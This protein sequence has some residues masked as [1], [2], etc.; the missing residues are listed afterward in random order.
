MAQMH[1][2]WFVD[3]VNADLIHVSSLSG[4]DFKGKSPFQDIEI[5]TLGSFGHSLIL[6]GKVQSTEKDEVCYHET[7][8]HPTLLLHPTG[9]KRVFIGGGGEGATS[10]EVLKHK[11]VEDVVMVDIDQVCVD[12]CRKYMPKHSA[13]AFDDPRHKLIIED[14]KKILEESEDGSYDAIILDLADPLD[15]GPCYQ[16]YTDSFYSMCRN[17]LSKDGILITQSGPCG[18]LSA[19]EVFS[20]IHATLRSVFPDST[21]MSSTLVLSFMD[22]YGFNTALNNKDSTPNPIK[23][24][25]EEID[26]RIEERIEGGHNALVWYDG[27]THQR[28]FHLPKSIRQ[29][30]EKERRIITKD[31][32][33]FMV[34]S[35]TPMNKPVIL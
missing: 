5:I 4:I 27:I 3:P 13:G 11:T 26:R 8:V 20:P 1:N 24:S 9:V 19:H 33:I 18:H 30:C 6:D 22:E 16:L 25:V 10:R 2:K 14:A 28:L 23:I 31:N 17:K 21:Y 29:L 15:G 32:Y 35:Q 12:M 7:L 34:D